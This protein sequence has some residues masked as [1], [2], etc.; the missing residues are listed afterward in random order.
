MIVTSHPSDMALASIQW[1]H[2][3]VCRNLAVVSVADGERLTGPG[4]VDEAV[5]GAVRLSEDIAIID[6]P[7]YSVDPPCAAIRNVGTSSAPISPDTSLC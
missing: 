5:G 1:A 3:C 6:V 2:V 7:V 4:L